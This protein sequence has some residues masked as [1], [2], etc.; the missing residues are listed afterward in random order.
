MIKKWKI[1][2][3]SLLVIV[4][5]FTL[6]LSLP[7][8]KNTSSPKKN[9]SVVID[10]GHGGID[11]GAVGVLTGNKESDLNLDIAFL[12]GEKLQDVGIDVVYTRTTQDGLYGNLE[13]GFKRRDMLERKRI[14]QK[15]NADMVIS[16][17]LNKFS[18]SSRRG[19]QVYFQKNDEVSALLASSVQDS[20]NTFINRPQQSRTFSPMQGD[21]WMCKITSPAI[22]VECGFLSNKEDDALL[23]TQ[24]YRKNVAYYIFNGI[25]TYFAQQTSYT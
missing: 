16:I 12:L 24:S 20:L 19:A 5:V 15:A 6:V 4:L 17:H 7:N 8:D 1:L 9:I 2:L 18:L 25:I 11:G 23:D 10:A 22:I 13:S 21:F 14:V 3:S